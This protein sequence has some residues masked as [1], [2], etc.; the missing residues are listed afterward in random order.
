M[1]DFPPKKKFVKLLGQAS[2]QIYLFKGFIGF[3]NGFDII[4]LEKFRNVISGALYIRERM[5][6]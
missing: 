1:Y 5:R 4:F 6:S 3:E 2:R